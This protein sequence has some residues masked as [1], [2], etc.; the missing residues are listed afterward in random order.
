MND[1][2]V[3]NHAMPKGNGSIQREPCQCIESMSRAK[4]KIKMCRDLLDDIGLVAF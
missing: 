2:I 3:V 4:N 1:V